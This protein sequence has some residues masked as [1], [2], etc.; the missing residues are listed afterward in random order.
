LSR[1]VTI[2]QHITVELMCAYWRSHRLLQ[3]ID[4]A[5]RKAW[6]TG[7]EDQWCDYHMQSIKAAGPKKTRHRIRTTFDQDAAQAKFGKSSEDNG[8]RNI[9]ICRR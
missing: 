6:P 3:A 1:E 9:S 5:E 2:E 4:R 8:W 7:T